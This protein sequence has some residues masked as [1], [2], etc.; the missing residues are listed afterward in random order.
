M[1]PTRKLTMLTDEDVC[2]LLMNALDSGEWHS[3]SVS[4]LSFDTRHDRCLS[5]E[6][7]SSLHSTYR[8]KNMGFLIN[9]SSVQLWTSAKAVSGN[10]EVVSKRMYVPINNIIKIAYSLSALPMT[11]GLRDENALGKSNQLST[12]LFNSDWY[13]LH[14]GNVSNIKIDCDAL[15]DA[16]IETLAEI[17]CNRWVVSDVIGVPSGGLRLSEAILRRVVPTGHR[18]IVDDV[19]TTGTSMEKARKKSGWN[20]AIGVVVFARGRCPSWVTPLFDASLTMNPNSNARHLSGLCDKISDVF[21]LKMHLLDTGID[22]EKN[23]IYGNDHDG[24]RLDIDDL[25]DYITVKFIG[26]HIFCK[27]ESEVMHCIRQIMDKRHGKQQQ[28]PI[29]EHR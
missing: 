20:S 19:L 24:E 27:N 8:D 14:S 21:G 29:D 1:T 25:G 17:I 22:Y 2:E 12:N 9:S 16:D 15:T 5:G 18:L 11:N 3:P 26:E 28:E 7:T 13:E 4:I 23:R 6:I 10:G